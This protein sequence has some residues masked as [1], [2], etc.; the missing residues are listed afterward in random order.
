MVAVHE[1][2]RCMYDSELVI[3]SGALTAL[4]R[5]CSEA[6]VWCGVRHSVGTGDE[7]RC[8]NTVRFYVL[9]QFN[10]THNNCKWSP[11]HTGFN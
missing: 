9:D 11:I 8:D 7:D 2:L 10:E 6:G 4:K 1:C 5:L 3:R